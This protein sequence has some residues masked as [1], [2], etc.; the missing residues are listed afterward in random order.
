[1]SD[2]AD[3]TARTTA[4]GGL[5]RR[6]KASH[7]LTS[8]PTMGDMERRSQLQPEVGLDVPAMLA[9]LLKP[10]GP[11]FRRVRYVRH[12][13][14]RYKPRDVLLPRGF[15]AAVVATGLNTPVAC[16][17]DEAGLCYVVEGGHKV[18]VAP[19]IV[20]VDPATGA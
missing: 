17:F 13:G 7:Q 12:G 5:L 3:E 14:R 2:G 20:R 10:L 16:C 18:N 4:R 8:P 15:V 1:M 11:V 19:R 9:Q 6:E